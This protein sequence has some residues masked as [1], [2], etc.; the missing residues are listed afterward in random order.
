MKVLRA[1]DS[2]A[3]SA[4]RIDTFTGEVWMDPVLP[5]TD[6]IAV[7][8]VWFTPGARTFWHHH[9][10]GQLLC[11][12]TGRGLVCAWGE[13]PQ[14]LHAGDMV[15]TPPGER[16]WHGGSATTCMSHLAVSLG[17]TDWLDA[18][19]EDSYLAEPSR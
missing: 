3:S 5:A 18:V 19:D 17:T 4:R 2:Y 8:H 15:W 9:E 16:H 11:A 14:L 6:G 10:R 7:N 1:S 13:R 12:T